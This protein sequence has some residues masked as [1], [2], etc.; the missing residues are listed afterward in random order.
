M[1][2]TRKMN[3]FGNRRGSVVVFVI[4]G[5]M[6]MLSIVAG[7]VNVGMLYE[8]KR[9][10]QNAADA[11][12]LAG[13]VSL[14]C[15]TDTTVQKNAR[16][17]AYKVANKNKAGGSFVDFSYPDAN[18]GEIQVGNWNGTS[19]SPTI[20]GTKTDPVNAIRVQNL[21]NNTKTVRTFF[22]KVLGISPSPI[23][24]SAVAYNSDDSGG[25]GDSGEVILTNGHVDPDVT[26][27]PGGTIRQ[28]QR[29]TDAALGLKT[30]PNTGSLDSRGSLSQSDTV[31]TTSVLYDSVN[32]RHGEQI[33]FTGTG[34][35]TLYV[36]GDFTISD[37]NPFIIGSSVTSLTIY[38]KGVLTIKGNVNINTGTAAS[39]NNN[40]VYPTKPLSIYVANNNYGEH[41]NENNNG[42]VVFQSGEHDNINMNSVIYAHGQ[43]N[44]SGNND[45]TVT[46]KLV[47][48]GDITSSGHNSK[49]TVNPASSSKCGNSPP[50]LVH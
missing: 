28:D 19:F 6:M 14:G 45:V 32:L 36:A 1:D 46:G 41:N 20:T 4:V 40:K 50:K 12:A 31:S 39:A 15:S 34:D 21:S 42:A 29:L 16:E 37:T 9:G 18:D 47:S 23:G 30:F 13:I 27:G 49:I 3:L 25:S 10:Y 33:T 24:F 35:V 2:T 38:V 43:I 48:S 17:M 8:S 11:A 7:V 22:A 5:I 44:G 26:A